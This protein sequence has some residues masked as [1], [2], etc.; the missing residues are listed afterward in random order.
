MGSNAIKTLPGA[1]TPRI[2][3]FINPP[4]DL[5][6]GEIPIT[7]PSH[8]LVLNK[9][10]VIPNHFI[11]AT[12]EFKDQRQLLEQDDLA[13]TM[14]C[15]RAWEGESSTQQT[16]LFAFFNSGR[17]SGASQA[18]RHIQFLP[19]ED[20]RGDDTDGQWNLKLD[21][22]SDESA[23]SMGFPFLH[24]VTQ[25][26][27]TLTS[28]DVYTLYM[29][30]YKQAAS[31]VKTYQTHRLSREDEVVVEESKQEGWS[32]ISYNLAMTTSA[33]AIC[34]RRRED[35]YIEMGVDDEQQ[36]RIGPA[37]LNGT[38]LAGTLMVKTQREWDA[39]REDDGSVLARM[40]ET[41]G[42]PSTDDS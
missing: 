32:E 10:P 23:P 12:K 15:L 38:I 4:E 21:S 27:P 31:A 36:N 8:L 28:A 33:M 17:H 14:A 35:A 41:V 42:F 22:L 40:L 24:F 5:L 3:P 1:S 26:S 9:Y 25:L 16:R 7:R 19:V 39:L 37:S 20:I 34:P 29:R 13:A 6:I 18:H 2:D 11:I 30:L